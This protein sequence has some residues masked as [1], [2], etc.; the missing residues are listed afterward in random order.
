MWGYNMIIVISHVAFQEDQLLR[1]RDE[2]EG[3][4]RE[5]KNLSREKAQVM[6]EVQSFPSCYHLYNKWYSMTGFD[7]MQYDILYDRGYEIIWYALLWYT[8]N[9]II[10]F[11]MLWLL[12]GLTALIRGVKNSLP[13]WLVVSFLS[14]QPHSRRLLTGTGQDLE[15]TEWGKGASSP[16]FILNHAPSG[17]SSD[18][19]N[20]SSIHLILYPIHLY[21][22]PILISH[23]GVPKG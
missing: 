21:A 4:E 20:F 16:A 1:L 3:V 19:F 7:N 18:L 22:H 15:S 5:N 2:K 9:A 10:I 23:F 6:D 11:D 12:S 14:D 13:W 8:K 17:Y